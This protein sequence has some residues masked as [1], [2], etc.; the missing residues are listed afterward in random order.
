MIKLV[1][2]DGKEGEMFISI[3]HG[4]TYTNNKQKS[5]KSNKN[6]YILKYN[7]LICDLKNNIKYE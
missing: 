6:T 1:H 2:I 5:V 3:F 7:M 4:F